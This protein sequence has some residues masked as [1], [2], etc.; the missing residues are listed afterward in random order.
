[1]VLPRTGSA[2]EAGSAKCATNDPCSN[3]RS[4]GRDVVE[5]L[6]LPVCLQGAVVMP[7][8]SQQIDS[9]W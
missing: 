5:S 7:T 8:L 4:L 1:M 2:A 6:E 9:C 3:T